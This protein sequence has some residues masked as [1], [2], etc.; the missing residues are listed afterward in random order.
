MISAAEVIMAA[1][2]DFGLD[3]TVDGVTP[4]RVIPHLSAREQ[5]A[6]GAGL[7]YVVRS[8]PYVVALE[9]AVTAAGVVSGNNGSMLTISGADY[10]V[11][12]IE[13]DR[14]GGVMLLLE[15]R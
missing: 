9:S 8:S 12:D 4:L 3:A 11:I 10:T 6:D 2:A 14:L 5:V 7:D 1:L 13:P 15:E